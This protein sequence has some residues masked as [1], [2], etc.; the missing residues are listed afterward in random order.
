MQATSFPNIA[1]HYLMPYIL[2]SLLLATA[3]AFAESKPM[4]AEE[5]LEGCELAIRTASGERFS[6]ID[7]FKASR[8]VAYVDGYF[9]SLAMV[10]HLNPHVSIV[11]FSKQPPNAV[12]LIRIVEAIRSNPK[13]RAEGTARIVVMHVAQS[14][15]N[16]P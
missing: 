2:I 13:V 12:I 11:D 16:K 7:S 4:T 14:L 9:D 10:Q 3:P 5:L 6:E 15:T 8:A 1:T